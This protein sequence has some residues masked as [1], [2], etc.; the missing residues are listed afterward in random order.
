MG[1]A[2]HIQVYKKNY[3]SILA[4]SFILNPVAPYLDE[5]AIQC[6]RKIIVH[7]YT[8][9]LYQIQFRRYQL[10]ILTSAPEIDDSAQHMTRRRQNLTVAVCDGRYRLHE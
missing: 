6:D 10:F 9:E 7:I 8:C 1:A 4:L 2:I 5:S 3:N